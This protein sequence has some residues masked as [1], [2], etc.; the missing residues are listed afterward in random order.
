MRLAVLLVLAPLAGCCTSPPP[1][2]H[3][4]VACIERL[5][6]RPSVYAD[7]EVAAM[8]DGQMVRAL[9]ADRLA[10]RAYALEL[11]A[12]AGACVR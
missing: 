3:V 6:E 11:G 7:A 2:E 9:H 8:P 1:P 4:P 5:P 10:W 12:V